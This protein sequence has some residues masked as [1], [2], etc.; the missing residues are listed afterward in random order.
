MLGD[1][2]IWAKRWWKQNITCR[3]D[4]KYKEINPY[5][6][7]FRCSKCGRIKN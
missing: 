1:L 4:Y 2:I 7:F 6:S 3:H 5:I